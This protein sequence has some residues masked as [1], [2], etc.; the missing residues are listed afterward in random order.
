MQLGDRTRKGVLPA[1]RNLG[2]PCAQGGRN[3]SH[4]LSHISRVLNNLMYATKHAPH[5]LHGNHFLKCLVERD[6]QRRIE[7]TQILNDSVPSWEKVF[8]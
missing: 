4:V 1:A 7:G 5:L 8:P 6:H 2:L 3:H